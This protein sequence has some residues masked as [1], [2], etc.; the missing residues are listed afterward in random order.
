MNGFHLGLA[1]LPGYTA[2][3]SSH[4]YDD[5]VKPASQTSC[6]FHQIEEDLRLG[7]RDR[8]VQPRYLLEK[9]AGPGRADCEYGG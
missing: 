8:L 6:R 7:M 9:V 5:Y 3:A 1:Q 4:D 2:F